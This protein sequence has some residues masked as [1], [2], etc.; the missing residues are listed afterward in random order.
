L[1]NKK[2]NLQI[3][4][5]Y[6]IKPFCFNESLVLCS[7]TLY[8]KIVMLRFC[9]LVLTILIINVGC[10]NGS[11]SKVETI[12][13]KNPESNQAMAAELKQ[14]ELN[15]DPLKTNYKNLARATT[16]LQHSTTGN[17][18][19]D[20]NTKLRAGYEFMLAGKNEKA[21]DIFNAAYQKVNELKVNSEAKKANRLSLLFTILSF[22]AQT[23]FRI[24]ENENCQ[25]NHNEA[26][27]LL[28]FQEASFHKLTQGSDNAIKDILELL[29]IKEDPN[30][31][32]LLN[33][34]YATLG[35]YPSE[36]PKQY[37][38]PLTLKEAKTDIKT[39]TNIA[40][41]IGVDDFRLSG[42]IA[43]EDFSGNGHLDI[44]ASSWNLKDQIKYYKNNGDGTFTESHQS[45][46][47]NGITG[48]LN[49]THADYN[50]DGH[51]D[52]LVLRG[53]WMKAGKHP[54]SLLKNNGDG[55]FTD[56]TKSSG[57]YS[58][59]PTQTAA[60]TDFNNDGFLDLF[61]GNESEDAQSINPCELFL[62]QKDG[63]F[64]NVA[65][66]VGANIVGFV[67]GVA[68]GDI[69]NDG[70]QDLFISVLSDKNILLRND[71]SKSE[72]GFKFTD[73][74]QTSGVQYPLESFPCWFFDFD[75]DGDQD[76]FSGSYSYK[77]YNNLSSEY[78]QEMSGKAFNSEP[79]KLYSN[80]GDGTFADV[81]KSYGLNKACF[82]MGSGFGDMNNDGFLDFYLGTGEP[83][84][85][86]VIPNRAFLNIEG[87]KFEEI[88]S[89]SGLGHVQKGH[90][91]SFADLDNDGD[92]DIYAVMGGAYEGD[93]FFN[94]LFENP[95]HN[96]QWIKLDLTGNKSNRD[97]I[98][99]HIKL[100]VSSG[101]GSRNIYRTISSGSSFGENPHV[102]NIGFKNGEQISGLEVKWPSGTVQA[103]KELNTNT[104]YQ[105]T[106]G[107]EIKML[108]NKAFKFKLNHKHDHSHH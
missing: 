50:N 32:W 68:A 88:T 58:L 54:N 75:N 97:G 45:A 104:K 67:K 89:Q 42:G 69:D 17:T 19:Q 106:E 78:L 103:F 15:L 39:F 41:L 29:K 9:I 33:M 23:H 99:A 63:R 83:D 74:S 85:K 46:G 64:K 90:A 77:S 27:C 22:R 21:L 26:S 37:L 31:V 2:V 86:A 61:I 94:A 25:N 18:A 8:K 100:V 40:S 5:Y 28:P 60:W 105:L 47:F 79:P 71:A 57:I 76:I 102:L 4:K 65:T 34:A 10:E 3:S 73:I 91:V 101:Q 7:L 96:N 14:H 84:L 44:I 62:N 98:G 1:S 108:E 49:I 66:L 16:F 38:I 11:S 51:P 35:K 55:T 56:V 36:V 87:Q 70:D 72:A 53:A 20:L 82:I 107:E 92:E 81:T 6:H 30:Y 59:H 95:G 93:V 12:E 80:N 24:G 48:G 43:V 52:I 13:Q